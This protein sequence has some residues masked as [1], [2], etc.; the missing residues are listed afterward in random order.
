LVLAVPVLLRIDV[1]FDVYTVPE[2]LL[3]SSLDV[4]E[5]ACELF[6][7]L[8]G[9]VPHEEAVVVEGLVHFETSD[10]IFVIVG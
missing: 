8:G 6:G 9:E 1:F 4:D 2:F 3:F 7:V 5:K 10:V